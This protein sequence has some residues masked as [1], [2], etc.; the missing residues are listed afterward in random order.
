MF[1]WGIIPGWEGLKLRVGRVSTE[2]TERG[3]E[4]G[5]NN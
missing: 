1:G 3:A 2:S 4:Y 5:R